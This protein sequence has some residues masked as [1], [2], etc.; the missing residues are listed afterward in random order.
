MKKL[1]LALT[2]LFS[3]SAFSGEILFPS[4][5]NYEVS[6]IVKELK[7]MSS[8]EIAARLYIG[9]LAIQKLTRRS[10]VSFCNIPKLG[11]SDYQLQG[12][13][14]AEINR[15][16]AIEACE[17]F[18]REQQSLVIEQLEDDLDRH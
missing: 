7:S 18:L 4:V 6:N 3:M 9:D 10:R 5:S 16:K 11:F 13:S 14:Q 17:D 2:L 12:K 8:S 15:D 1:T